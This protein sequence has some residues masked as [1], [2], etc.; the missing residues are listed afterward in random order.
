MNID[1]MSF[2]WNKFRS[3]LLNYIKKKIQNEADAEDILQEV[4]IK[5]YVNFEHLEHHEKLRS[6]LYTITNNAIIDFFRNKKDS[7]IPLEKVENLSLTPK[8]L[9]NMNDEMLVCLSSILSEL[10][11]KYRLPL[12]MH[13]LKGIK[14]KEI[15]EILDISLSGSKTRVQRAKERLKKVLTDCC[16]FEFDA[17]GNILDYRRHEKNKDCKDC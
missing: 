12:E 14:H 8:E 13:D 7:T 5:M 15:A 17:Y 4:F 16:E 1:E 3:E 9:P 11:E 10:P 2:A 6:W